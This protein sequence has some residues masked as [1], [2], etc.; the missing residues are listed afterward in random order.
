MRVNVRRRNVR[1]RNA[2]ARRHRAGGERDIAAACTPMLRLRGAQALVGSRRRRRECR[3]NCD[4]RRSAD[5]RS[6]D[7]VRLYQRYRQ[8]RQVGRLGELRRF[9]SSNAVHSASARVYGQR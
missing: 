1:R 6:S 8:E 4:R 7:G 3:P 9:S 5:G 2:M